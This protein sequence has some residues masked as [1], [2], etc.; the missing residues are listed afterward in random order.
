MLQNYYYYGKKVA[1]QIII[2][3]PKKKKKKIIHLISVCFLF[4]LFLVDNWHQ[5]AC[6]NN[7]NAN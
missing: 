1:P 3:M 6:L 5:I 4:D 7:A 2:F